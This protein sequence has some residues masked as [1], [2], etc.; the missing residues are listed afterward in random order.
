M[1]ECYTKYMH[2]VLNCMRTWMLHIYANITTCM[3]VLLHL[4]LHICMNVTLHI[5]TRC[6]IACAHECCT[7][8]GMLL[9]VR[10]YYYMCYHNIYEYYTTY[11]HEYI[12]ILYITYDSYNMYEHYTAHMHECICALPHTCEHIKHSYNIYEYCI[13]H[14]HEYVWILYNM[15]DSYSMYERHTTH[16]HECI[17]VLPD[18]SEYIDIEHSYNL[19]EYYTAHMQEYV[20]ILYNMYDSY[21]MYE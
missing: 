8:M 13:T 9:H 19:Y 10:A 7:H 1:Y 18:T 14:M 12:W 6:L 20:W 11:M 15:Y 17:C 21:N 3:C 2:E 5:C 16:M 4:L